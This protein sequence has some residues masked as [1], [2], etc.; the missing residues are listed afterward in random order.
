MAKRTAKERREAL[1]AWLHRYRFQRPKNN[2]IAS[3][4]PC[5]N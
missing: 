3:E 1:G 5:E 2:A 4:L